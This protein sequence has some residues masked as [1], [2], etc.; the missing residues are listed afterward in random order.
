APRSTPLP[1]SFRR[2]TKNFVTDLW[3]YALLPFASWKRERLVTKR[4]EIPVRGL[5]PAF[6][7]YRIVFLTDL[8]IS[9]LVPSWWLRRAMAAAVAL[10]PDLIALGGDFVDDDVH[11]VPQLGDI[12]SSLQARDGVV[13]VLGNHDHYVG[14]H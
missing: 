3:E 14:A 2:R 5:D 7:G 11:F 8:H 1:P 9:P 10:E 12:L 6:D 13:G 4:V